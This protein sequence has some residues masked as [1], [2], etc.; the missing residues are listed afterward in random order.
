MLKSE[1]V[2]KIA[3]RT[4]LTKKDAVAAVDAYHDIVVE[5][6]KDGDSVPLKGFG[7]YTTSARKARVGRNPQNKEPIDIPASVS[8]AFK[9]SKRVKDILNSK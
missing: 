2:T 9:P 1:F 4:G 6:A 8:L 3:D 5:A 7:T